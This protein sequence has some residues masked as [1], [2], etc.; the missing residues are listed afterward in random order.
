MKKQIYFTILWKLKIINNS[1]SK[2][3]RINSETNTPYFSLENHLIN[4]I[5][6]S[7]SSEELVCVSLCYTYDLCLHLLGYKSLVFTLLR[8]MVCHGSR[9]SIWPYKLICKNCQY[10]TNLYKI[11][12][13]LRKICHCIDMQVQKILMRQYFGH[14][15]NYY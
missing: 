14:A 15:D 4:L 2:G 10:L 12:K 13:L 7:L 6:T 3:M 1:L 5:Y 11:N 8:I 9:S